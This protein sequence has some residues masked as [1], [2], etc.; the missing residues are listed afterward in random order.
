MDLSLDT[1][2]II[3]LIIETDTTRRAWD[4]LNALPHRNNSLLWGVPFYA[5]ISVLSI[6]L[7]KGRDR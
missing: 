7:W 4:F 2:F 1:S 6:H 3:P 5:G